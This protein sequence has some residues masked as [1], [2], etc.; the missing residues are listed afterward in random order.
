MEMIINVKKAVILK[1]LKR[2]QA[3]TGYLK[4]KIFILILK[5]FMLLKNNRSGL[6][7]FGGWAQI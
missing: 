7:G 4:F 6:C 2:E 5:L 3:Q 1:V